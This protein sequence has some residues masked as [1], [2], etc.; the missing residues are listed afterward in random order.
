MKYSKKQL[1]IAG[2]LIAAAAASL[3]YYFTR[4]KTEKTS[5][6]NLTDWWNDITGQND[7]FPIKYGSQGDAVTYLQQAIINAYDN[8]LEGIT[9]G[10][11]DRDTQ[12]VL[13]AHRMPL[14]Y[15]NYEQIDNAFA[16]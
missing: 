5:N 13:V 2:S 14:T 1:I 16:N 11:W 15:A 7:G 9:T 10:V 4:K 12:N 6:F 3:T 8:A